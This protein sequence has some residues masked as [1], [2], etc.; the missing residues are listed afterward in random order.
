MGRNAKAWFVASPLQSLQC[1]GFA[2]FSIFFMYLPQAQ[3][4]SAHYLCVLVFLQSL[5]RNVGVCICQHLSL[6]PYGSF[7]G[8]VCEILYFRSSSSLGVCICQNL[9]LQL[10]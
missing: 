4:I 5:F 2:W 8:T 10:V 7:G 9:F 1:T 3:R 6:S